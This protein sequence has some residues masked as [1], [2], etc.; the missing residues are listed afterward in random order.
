MSSEKQIMSNDKYQR[1]FSIEWRLL[2]F[3]SLLSFPN[4]IFSRHARSENWGTSLGYSPGLAG[5][6]KSPDE[7][8]PVLAKIFDGSKVRVLSSVRVCSI[9]I[10]NE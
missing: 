4:I 6:I 1:F 3:L 5:H 9:V 10:R 7:F 8:N 2:C